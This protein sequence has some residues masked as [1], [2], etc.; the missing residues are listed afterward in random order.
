MNGVD[1]RYRILVARSTG[2]VVHDVNETGV[3]V[4]VRE[5]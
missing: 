1:H 5:G 3:G 2:E 4:L